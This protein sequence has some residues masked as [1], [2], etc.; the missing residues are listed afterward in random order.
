MQRFLL[1]LAITTATLASLGCASG[2][3]PGAHYRQPARYP[4]GVPTGLIEPLQDDAY[5]PGNGADATGR[6]FRWR[7]NT[8]ETTSGAVQRNV[9]GP[10]IGMDAYGRPVTAEP[11]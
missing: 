8:G 10:G 3:P 1:R 7:T 9:Y 5:G 2:A 6:P 4:S 11:R